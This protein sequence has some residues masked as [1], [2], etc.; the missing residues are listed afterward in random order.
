M[1]YDFVGL[2]YMH[3]MHGTNHAQHFSFEIIYVALMHDINIKLV[4]N[5]VQSCRAC[6]LLEMMSFSEES[7]HQSTLSRKF[8]NCLQAAPMEG[9]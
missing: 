6:G 8:Q 2:L 1:I 7:R 3:N 4:L 9:Q 5:Y